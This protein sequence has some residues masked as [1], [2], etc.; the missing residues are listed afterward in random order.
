MKTDK[1]EET[2]TAITI[3]GRD[4]KLTA[5]IPGISAYTIRGF[6]RPSCRKPRWAW[7]KRTWTAGGTA[8]RWM[9]SFPV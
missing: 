1:F 6:T 9:N 4:Q 8:P 3:A 2:A 7:G 5:V